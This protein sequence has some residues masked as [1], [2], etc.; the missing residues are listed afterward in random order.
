MRP[1][2]MAGSPQAQLRDV[3]ERTWKTRRFGGP[4]TEIKE[5]LVSLTFEIRYMPNFFLSF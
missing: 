5:T 2:V 1:L 3:G 4:G